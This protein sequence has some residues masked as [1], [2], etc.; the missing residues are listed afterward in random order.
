[1]SRTTISSLQDLLPVNVSEADAFTIPAPPPL[2]ASVSRAGI[3]LQNDMKG[4]VYL[5]DDH[6]RIVGADHSLVS[7][8]SNGGAHRASPVSFLAVKHSHALSLWSKSQSFNAVVSTFAAFLVIRFTRGERL[9]YER[10]AENVALPGD[11]HPDAGR[12]CGHPPGTGCPF[13]PWSLYWLR[14]R[15]RSALYLCQESREGDVSG[16]AKMGFALTGNLPVLRLMPGTMADQ[17]LLGYSAVVPMYLAGAVVS[18]SRPVA[19]F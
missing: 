8:L 17:Q 13:A 10:Q 11:Y 1:M 18:T 3:R 7:T 9:C 6:G 14:V 4:S 15:L 5:V 19:G 2:M 16:F 12:G